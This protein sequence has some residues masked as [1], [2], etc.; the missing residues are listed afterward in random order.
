M[1]VSFR[2]SA[3]FGSMDDTASSRPK[4]TSASSK[5]RR[6]AGLHST[7]GRGGSGAGT[8]AW[9]AS[10]ATATVRY[11][12]GGGRCMALIPFVAEVKLMRLVNFTLASNRN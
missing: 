7:G 8:K 6:N 4:A 2:S 12:P 5:R 1:S 3:A 10:P 9:K 11:W